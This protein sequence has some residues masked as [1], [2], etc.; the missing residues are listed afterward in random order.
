MYTL[1]DPYESKEQ[2]EY[3]KWCRPRTKRQMYI[4]SVYTILYI[5]ESK[6]SNSHHGFL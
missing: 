1:A 6:I 3:I 4:Y 5:E 2:N